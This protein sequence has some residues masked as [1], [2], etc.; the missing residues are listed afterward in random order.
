MAK[1]RE[2]DADDTD[3]AEENTEPET[4]R[5][6][7]ITHNLADGGIIA[8]RKNIQRKL[9]GRP[10]EEKISLGM[11]NKKGDAGIYLTA[12]KTELADIIKKFE[13]RAADWSYNNP[14]FAFEEVEEEPEGI[15]PG[16]DLDRIEAAL[17]SGVVEERNRQY[18]EVGSLNA[19]LDAAKKEITGL[20][21]KCKDFDS[22]NTK[23]TSAYDTLKEQVT[24]LKKI[25]ETLKAGNLTDS[26]IAFLKTRAES[27]ETLDM[28]LQ[29][30]KESG[31]DV[32]FILNPPESAEKCARDKVMGQFKI[33][34]Q[35]LLSN[36]ELGKIDAW[37]K[38]SFYQPESE[39]ADVK[40]KIQGLQKV[41]DSADPHVKQIVE[42]SL[43]NSIGQFNEALHAYQLKLENWETA[44]KVSVMYHASV[45]EFQESIAKAKK[46]Q[47]LPADVKLTKV[48]VFVQYET[49]CAALYTP[50]EQGIAYESLKKAIDR[51]AK[52]VAE[53]CLGKCMLVKI[54]AKNGDEWKP[55]EILKCIKESYLSTEAGMLGSKLGMIVQL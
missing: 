33:D 1:H 22:Q 29:E 16:E 7:R 44:H 32:M 8:L 40:Q 23:L 19:K 10:G 26:L 12:T 11:V 30:L 50:V 45:A 27:L 28:I 24:A 48:P 46:L 21:N 18:V 31:L 49:D 5:K 6:Y 35:Q 54:A 43:K 52:I 42:D 17:E 3:F 25:Q 41:I 14:H 37:P 9:Y 51:H 39:I 34:Y 53:E 20:E 55:I 38:C 4:K 2:E 47:S 15:I 36:L 13:E